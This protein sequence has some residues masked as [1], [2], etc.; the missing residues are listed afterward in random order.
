[1][2]VT[3]TSQVALLATNALITTVD[4]VVDSISTK[5]D[6][7]DT[8]CDGIDTVVDSVLAHHHSA[9]KVYPTLAAAKELICGA[10]WTLGSFVEVVP[11]STITSAFC[12]VGINYESSDEET[13]DTY[14]VVL[15][16]GESD[17]ECARIRASSDGVGSYIPVSTPSI[18]ANSKIRAKAASAAGSNSIFI[19]IAYVVHA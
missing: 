3:S 1:M 10:A 8:V 11:A 4:T 6:T 14:E 7:V 19:S 2:A 12:V 5:V 16:Y 13:S 17:V 15:Y 9:V 18:P